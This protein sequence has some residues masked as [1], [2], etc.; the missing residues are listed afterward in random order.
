MLLSFDHFSHL[1][2]ISS[3]FGTKQSLWL[4]HL[5]HKALNWTH[6]SISIRRELWRQVPKSTVNH[7]TGTTATPTNLVPSIGIKST[8][9]WLPSSASMSLLPNA[10]SSL[11][12]A[13]QASFLL[14]PFFFFSLFF[15]LLFRSRSWVHASFFGFQKN[16]IFMFFGFL[17]F[18][19][20]FAAFS[21]GMVVDGGY[22]DVVNIDI[23]SVV[24]EAMKSKYR[25]FPQL[26]C[27]LSALWFVCVN[28]SCYGIV[29]EFNCALLCLSMNN[30]LH[31]LSILS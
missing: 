14:L 4:Q 30:F 22:T 1:L 23:S 28:F 6:H 24:I 12:V 5:P 13:T 19:V 8:S 16:Y 11:V 2:S 25:D 7:G 21:E 3:R 10:S 27:I 20:V 26:K 31:Y 15:R 18:V 17:F 9:L 29:E